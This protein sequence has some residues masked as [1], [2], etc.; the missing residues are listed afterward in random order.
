MK[1]FPL[2]LL[3][4]LLS[5]LL[6]AQESDCDSDATL[7]IQVPEGP[8][9]WTSLDLNNNPCQFQFAIVTDRTGG[10][11]PGVF[12][13]G[14]RR[15]NLLQPEF[16]MSVGD[17]IEGYTEDRTVLEQEWNEFEGFIDSLDMPFF[18]VPG[19]HDITNKVMEDVWKEKFGQTYYH[20]TYKDVLFLAL[21]TEDQYR[22]SNKGTI[23]DEQYAY[24]EKTLAENTNVKWTLVFMH[25]PLWILEDTKRWQDVE[26][27][28][29]GRKHTVFVGHHHR[30]AKYERNN[31]KYFML[32]TT[33]GGSN[34]RGPQLGEFDH[35]VWITMTDEGPIIANLQLEGIWNEDVVTEQTKDFLAETWKRR[36]IA[37]EPLLVASDEFDTGVVKFKIT[38]DRDVPM[39]VKLKNSFSWDMKSSLNMNKVEVAPNSVEFVE[40]ELKAKKDKPIA[41]LDPVKVACSA[42]YK[43]EGMPEVDIPFSFN[44]GPELS[45]TVSPIDKI[46]VDGQLKDWGDMPFS[47]AAEDT[48]DL[49]AQFQVAYD[50]QFFY[51]AAKVEDD[52]ILKDTA[53]APWNQDFVGFTINADPMLKSAI[54]LGEGWY[55]NS[56]FFIQTPS[57]GKL[58]STSYY[59]DQL[60]EGSKCITRATKTGYI[61]E[62][63]VPIA[64]F[65]ER[66]GKDWQT[67]RVNLIVQ[68]ADPGEEKMP[69]YSWQPAWNGG[70]NRIGSGMFFKVK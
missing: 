53:A 30:Y 37:P 31:G 12:L 70:G 8:K 11:R 44:I 57:M 17:L 10:H 9:P 27:L 39:E 66:Q 69:R 3:A 65:H 26:T 14:I 68:D 58:P 20:F 55:K 35:V 1:K 13:E 61:L 18:Y 47:I 23:S 43:G 41:D 33:G 54:D 22:G 45:Y 49:N 19:N 5:V 42:T 48:T 60:P 51:L 16:V 32:A 4:T 59:D 63:A 36:P 52:Q 50:D 28:L 38:N 24:I 62:L 67:A 34:L 7:E 56:V 64:Y 21:N 40:L 6:Y 15:L 25:Q 46:K 29:A 2:L